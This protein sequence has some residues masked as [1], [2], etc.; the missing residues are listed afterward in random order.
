MEILFKRDSRGRKPADPATGFRT[1]ID[2]NCQGVTI[3]AFWRHSRV[4]QINLKDGR[5]L[6]VET[7]VNAAED[8]GCQ[9]RLHNLS[10]LQ[11]LGA[12]DQR[13]AAAN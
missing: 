12:C 9:R 4:K 3:N 5:A 1:A 11:A 8:L 13:P 7:V 6:R 10:E 2:R